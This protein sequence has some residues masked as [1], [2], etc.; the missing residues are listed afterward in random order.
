MTW[1]VRCSIVVVLAPDEED[2]STIGVPTSAIT[3]PTGTPKGEA[4]LQPLFF[5]LYL[6]TRVIVGDL[7]LPDLA[8][9]GAGTDPT[10]VVTIPAAPHSDAGGGTDPNGAK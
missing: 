10:E 7:T 8:K 1:E 4:M 2:T 9:T 5:V 3:P 6:I